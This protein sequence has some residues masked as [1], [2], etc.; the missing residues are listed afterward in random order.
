MLKVFLF[1]FI[2]NSFVLS[3]TYSDGDQISY[4]DQIQEINIINGNP[5]WDWDHFSLSQLNSA[6]NGGTPKVSVIFVDTI[7]NGNN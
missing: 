2:V 1:L 4:A 3:Q 5:S 6:F 7:L